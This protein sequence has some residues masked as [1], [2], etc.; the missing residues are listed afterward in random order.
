[1]ARRDG[2]EPVASFHEAILLED[3][4]LEPEIVRASADPLYFSWPLGAWSY[5]LRGRYAEQLGRW[6]DL[7]PR[8]QFHLVRTED[9]V[10]TPAPVLN[11]VC[12]FLGLPQH[13]LDEYPRYRVGSY[14]PMPAETRAMLTDYFRPH[15]ERLRE[16]VGIDFGWDVKMDSTLTT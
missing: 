1:M 12:A 9:F 6:F 7:F 4:R 5:L 11:G 10:S 15:N 13:E 14:S 8:E 2:E 3:K 16:L